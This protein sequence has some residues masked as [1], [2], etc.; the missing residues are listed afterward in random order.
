AGAGE[1]GH[2]GLGLGGLGAEIADRALLTRWPV[3]D[4]SLRYGW[5]PDP[6]GGDAGMV[7]LA[8]GLRHGE[9]ALDASGFARV[10]PRAGES[11]Q[12]DPALGARTGG[13]LG[14]R[15]FAGDLGVK[16]RLEAAWVGERVNA[17]LP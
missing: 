10:R 6:A 2:R 12:L 4:L 16:L 15:V 9:Y 1:R 11:A 3:R 17:S 7:T 5:S 14:F 13:E 8:G